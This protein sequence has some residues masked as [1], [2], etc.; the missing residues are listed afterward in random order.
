M[1]YIII[2]VAIAALFGPHLWAKHVLDK[3]NRQEY[4]SGT[5]IDLARMILTRLQLNG[6]TVE[7][8]D[9]GD[10]YDP[11]GKAIRPTSKIMMGFR[12]WPPSPVRRP[13]EC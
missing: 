8:T 4:F 1:V 9:S 6:V 7:I 5:G 13:S 12:C 10:H 2:V 3:Y 11:V